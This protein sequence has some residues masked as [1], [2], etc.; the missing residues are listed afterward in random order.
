MKSEFYRAKNSFTKSRKMKERKLETGQR[1]KLG[2]VGFQ[3][4]I[5]ITKLALT[6]TVLCDMKRKIS[7]FILIARLLSTSLQ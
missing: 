7:N 3:I 1:K 6:R 5:G 2:E 4:I